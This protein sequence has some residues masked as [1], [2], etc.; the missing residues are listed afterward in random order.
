M[1]FNRKG[2]ANAGAQGLSICGYKPRDNK[3]IDQMT[4]LFNYITNDN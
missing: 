2:I 1:I 3:A 4:A